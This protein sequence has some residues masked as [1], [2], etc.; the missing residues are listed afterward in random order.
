MNEGIQMEYNMK[1]YCEKNGYT[2]YIHRI[3]ENDNLN[4]EHKKAN[5]I[6]K[7]IDNH[8]YIIWVDSD[9]IC[10]DMD[11]KIEPLLKW[12]V[13]L[14]CFK[15]IIKYS[16][17][18]FLIFRNDN[19]SKV[20]INDWISSNEELMNL[21]IKKY[22]KNT[23]RDTNMEVNVPISFLSKNTRFI[24]LMNIT[25]FNKLLLLEYFNYLVFNIKYKNIKSNEKN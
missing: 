2:F 5:L 24:R 20:I 21:I 12:K 18:G 14:Y 23:Y 9:V 16:N 6:K 11:Y 25:G 8:K 13:S 10:F 22:L 1:T 7:Y 3:N 19:I 4:D 15:D 17:T